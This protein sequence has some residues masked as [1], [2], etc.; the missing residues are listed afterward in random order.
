MLPVTAPP[1]PSHRGAGSCVR[2]SA[3]GGGVSERPF[4][5]HVGPGRRPGPTCV[6]PS[7]PA[8]SVVC[9]DPRGVQ[10]RGPYPRGRVCHPPS[11]RASG[12]GGGVRAAPRGPSERC[13]RPTALRGSPTAR[14]AW[15][16]CGTTAGEARASRNVGGAASRSPCHAVETG[17]PLRSGNSPPGALSNGMSQG[18]KFHGLV[19]S[20][21]TMPR[22]VHSRDDVVL[23]NCCSCHSR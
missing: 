1:G 13:P 8:P 17:P 16:G 7:P 4:A 3:R 5:T 12:A 11:G 9:G 21:A 2:R 22:A 19:G 10:Y 23:S 14:T 6:V 18:S 15:C 20:R